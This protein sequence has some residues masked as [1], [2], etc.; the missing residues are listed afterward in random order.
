MYS[1]KMLKRYLVK[2]SI[3][4]DDFVQL[5]E[6]IETADAF[7]SAKNQCSKIIHIVESQD[8]TEATNNWRALMYYVDDSITITEEFLEM[9]QPLRQKIINSGLQ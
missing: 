9:Y 1:E 8:I 6:S 5:S 3:L 4:F 7:N 2:L